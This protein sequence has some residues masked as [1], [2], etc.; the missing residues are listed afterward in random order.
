MWAL[1]KVDSLFDTLSGFKTLRLSRLP[2]SFELFNAEW[3]VIR[4]NSS[5]HCVLSS[6]VVLMHM[7]KAC[8]TLSYQRN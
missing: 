8:V 2:V 5:F 7:V 3:Q 4:Q 1:D 6:R